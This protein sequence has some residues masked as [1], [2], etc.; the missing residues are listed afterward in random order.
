M[1]GDNRPVHYPTLINDFKCPV[2]VR[3]LL[4]PRK[5]EKYPKTKRSTSSERFPKRWS[6]HPQ[7]CLGKISHDS[8]HMSWVMIN[9]KGHCVLLGV[10][11]VFICFS[12]VFY[13]WW[14]VISFDLTPP[15]IGQA[16]LRDEVQA[17]GY[18]TRGGPEDAGMAHGTYWEWGPIGNG[19]RWAPT[20]SK[21]SYN[22]YKWSVIWV[23]G[24]ITLLI[25]IGL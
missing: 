24:V 3:C 16:G 5:A 4:D 14:V 8:C 2:L 9:R 25:L 7:K 6:H 10:L 23:T 13:V 21:L 22:P 1:V 20:S 15:K 18:R 17:L 12:L 19:T 11:Y